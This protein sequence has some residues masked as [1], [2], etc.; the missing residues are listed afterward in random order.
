MARWYDHELKRNALCAMNSGIKES[1]Q[2]SW[3]IFAYCICLLSNAVN[4]INIVS[5]IW[6]C[7]SN[8]I[9]INIKNDTR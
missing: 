2:N 4:S 3:D 7:V 9:L 8:T 6:G 1:C 5:I